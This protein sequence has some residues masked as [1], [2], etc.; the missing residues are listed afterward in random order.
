MGLA[1]GQAWTM[2]KYQSAETPMILFSPAMEQR[3]YELSQLRD[4]WYQGQG[5]APSPVAIS[6]VRRVLQLAIAMDAPEPNKIDIDFENVIEVL[7]L[8]SD[9]AAA[10][11]APNGCRLS[12]I[13]NLMT[14]LDGD[15][16]ERDDLDDLP[17]QPDSAILEL[18]QKVCFFND[19]SS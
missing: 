6:M 17:N 18:L 5:L 14:D 7:W 10:T 4:G 1:R 13:H 15:N 2:P 12:V 11:I 16:F 8:V 3:L 9:G 19:D